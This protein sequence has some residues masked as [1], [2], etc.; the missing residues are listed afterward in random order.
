[1]AEIVI[2]RQN[3]KF[4]T[5]FQ[6]ADT[7]AP[8]AASHKLRPIHAIHELTPYGM[9]L[10]GL[11]SCTAILLHSYAQNHGAKLEEV[12]IRLRYDRI[13]VK[14]CAE[15]EET[16]K[17]SEQIDAEVEFVG[18][19]TPTERNKLF[20]ISKHC[21]VHKI[22]HNGIHTEFRLAKNLQPA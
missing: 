6:Y 20:L 7:E 10:A 5:E 2:V 11:G 1:M 16:E 12:E 14:D 22:L 9:L 18:E 13:F 21:P 8:E 15:C 19:L 17:Y 3:S 4:E